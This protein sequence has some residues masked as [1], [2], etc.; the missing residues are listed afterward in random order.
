MAALHLPEH[1]VIDALP[2]AVL[3]PAAEALVARLPRAVA[4]GEIAPG[5]ARREHPEDA[6]DHLPVR[7]PWS[8][9]ARQLGRPRQQGGEHAPRG[10]S[11][12]M[13]TSNPTRS[14][15]PFSEAS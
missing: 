3:G 5:A 11:Q 15:C 6:V 4:R 2:G 1:R 7:A 14:S 12:F 8:P 9:L 10:V 13:T